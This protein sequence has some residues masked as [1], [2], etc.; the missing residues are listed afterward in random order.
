M[1]TLGEL[2]DA[3]LA[4]ASVVVEPTEVQADGQ[5]SWVRVVRSRTPALD[6]LEAG[7][8]VILPLAALPVVAPGPADATSLADAIA[9]PPAAG[10]LLVGDPDDREDALIG[11][12]AAANLPVLRV[13]ATDVGAIER[14]VIGFLVNRRAEIERQAT[15]LEERLHALA[16][17][18]ADATGLA[19]A[20]AE[21]LNRAV[22]LEDE[23][24]A[25]IAIHAPPGVPGSAAAAGAYLARPRTR[26]IR[27][28]L[29]G[30]AGALVVLGD[31]PLGEAA[32][33]ACRRIAPFLALE[34]GREA[35]VRRARDLERRA[36]TLPGGGPPWVVV[37]A[38]QGG[39]DGSDTIERREEVRARIRR[40]APGR[41]V[42]LRGDARSVELRVIA[43][44]AADDP[45]G[46]G[47]SARIGALLGRTVGVSE[48]FGDAAGRPAA[49][50]AAR[51][52]LEAADGLSQ[53]IDVARADRISVYRLLG[54]VHSAPDGLRH[55]RAL[56]AAASRRRS[57][58]DQRTVTT[59][60]ALVDHPSPAD[61]AAAL[62]VHRNTVLYRARVIEQ[63]T[64]WDLRDPDLRLALAIAVR[65]VQSAQF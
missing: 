19:A 32:A 11:A 40:L 50:A 10:V 46:L 62:G 37:V 7:D 54:S 27:I 29:P 5:L 30:R 48:P 49:E 45:A 26:A 25:S 1:P 57:A 13:P 33:Q 21:A 61:A 35:A 39:G 24:G 58:D 44:T 64:G 22:A 20:I 23:H 3:L 14:R 31:E 6:V 63:R 51:A 8:L 47:L 43:A 18:G 65:L 55:A 41:R 60:R 16:L 2:R 52:A 59:L 56:V 12:L 15:E 42:A 4:S 17:G 28:P 36:E 38:R 34:L 9:R 53:P